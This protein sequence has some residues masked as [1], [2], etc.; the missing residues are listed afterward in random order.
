MVKATKTVFKG[1]LEVFEHRPQGAAGDFAVVFCHGVA[2]S[3]ADFDPLLE[4]LGDY[5]F[6][7]FNL[8]GHNDLPYRSDE[9][10]LDR[11]ADL[12]TEWVLAKKLQKIVL[13]GHS[14]GA[15][16]VSEAANRLRGSAE[17]CGVVLVA[18]YNVRCA[19]LRTIMFL[20]VFFNTKFLQKYAA[21][22]AKTAEINEAFEANPSAGAKR[23]I[24][25]V[26]G[27]KKAIQHLVANLA[28]PATLNKTHQTYK[29]LRVPVHLVLAENDQIVPLGP[30][31]KYFL[32]TLPKATVK[33]FPKTTHVMPIEIPAAFMRHANQTIKKLTEK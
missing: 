30:T 26:A 11:Y 14:M 18:P 3:K 12:L 32:K 20:N 1:N 16:I 22:Y 29:S 4:Y 23:F 15:A 19:N 7:Q 25:F 9:I 6:Y 28:N 5:V 10:K 27:H 21:S 8:P 13:V 2:A 24:A 33:V 17:I 31:R